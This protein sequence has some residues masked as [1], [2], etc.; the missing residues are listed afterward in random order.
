MTSP[1]LA[2]RVAALYGHTKSLTETTLENC[3]AP[4]DETWVFAR[5]PA[6]ATLLHLLRRY[7]LDADRHPTH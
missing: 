1:L 7:L 3:F 4:G 5:P 2:Q 6:P